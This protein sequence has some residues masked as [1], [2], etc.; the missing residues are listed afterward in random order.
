ME[1]LAREPA[2]SRDIGRTGDLAVATPA[3]NRAGRPWSRDARSRNS[4]PGGWVEVRGADA[5]VPRVEGTGDEPVAGVTGGA[6][7][8]TTNWVACRAVEEFVTTAE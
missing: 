4:T 7:D 3:S 6:N 8:F 5:K 2:A 1:W